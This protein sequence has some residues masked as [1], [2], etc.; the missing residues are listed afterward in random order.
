MTEYEYYAEVKKVAVKFG[1]TEQQEQYVSMY[2]A[3]NGYDC[4]ANCWQVA[5]DTLEMVIDQNQLVQVANNEI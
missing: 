4:G 5:F 3:E 1:L 2:C